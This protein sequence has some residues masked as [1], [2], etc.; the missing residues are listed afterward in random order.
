MLKQ[1]NETRPLIFMYRNFFL[2]VCEK[3]EMVRNFWHISVMFLGIS[4]DNKW[5]YTSEPCSGI[6]T[7]ITTGYSLGHGKTKSTFPI[8]GW[9]NKIF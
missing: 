5:N 2:R 4:S 9:Q 6:C 1:N 7:T 8:F 3:E